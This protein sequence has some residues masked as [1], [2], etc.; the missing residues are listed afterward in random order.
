[1]SIGGISSRATA[2]LVLVVL[3]TILGFLVGLWLVYELQVIVVWGILATFLAVALGPSVSWMSRRGVPRSLAILIDYLLLVG[4]M[5]A[6]AALVVPP[7]I[8]QLNQLVHVLEQPGGVAGAVDRFAE[9]LGLGGLASKIEP[10]LDAAP[11]QIAGSIASLTT[12]TTGALGFATGALS[13]AVLGFFLLNDGARLKEGAVHL[14]RPARREQ[15]RRI[16]DGSASAIYGYIRGNLAISA[17]AGVSAFIGMAVLGIPYALPLA[18]L[19]AVVDLIPMVGVTVGAIPVV[20]VALSISPLKAVVILVYIVVYQ[21][22]E[23][24]VLNPLIYGRSDQLPAL[25]VFLAFVVGSTLFG[26]L[27]ALVA[28]PAANIIRILVR[29]WLSDGAPDP[30]APQQLDWETLQRRAERGATRAGSQQ[31]KP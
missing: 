14:V 19:L 11:G 17:I 31:T 23:S 25:V 1:M 10:Q 5:L 29:E 21:Q 18:V 9:P 15:A 12:V 3:L 22:I 16:L 8:S 28:I 13:V 6:V 2:R 7:L 24:N 30:A 4:V 20:L 26:I 27:G